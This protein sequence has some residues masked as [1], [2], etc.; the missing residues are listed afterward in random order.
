MDFETRNEQAWA[1]IRNEKAVQAQLRKESGI[2]DVEIFCSYLEET[3][4]EIRAFKNDKAFLVEMYHS[5]IK[6]LTEFFDE[7][8]RVV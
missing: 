1:A 2:D 8:Y 5:M 3:A 7:H 6:S 4:D